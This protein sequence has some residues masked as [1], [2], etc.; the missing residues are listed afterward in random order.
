MSLQCI[1][2]MIMQN[3]I[4]IILII[5]ILQYFSLLVTCL[6]YSSCISSCFMDSFN[7]FFLKS[8]N[9]EIY[10]LIT[11]ILVNFLSIVS[12]LNSSTS[13]FLSKS[14]SMS[15]LFVSLPFF[16]FISKASEFL[17]FSSSSDIST[18]IITS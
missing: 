18:E 9:K 7:N 4:A 13:Q 16:P 8:P 15:Y 11:S 17:L 12:Y 2:G 5:T 6:L 14:S 1:V 10:L 3:A